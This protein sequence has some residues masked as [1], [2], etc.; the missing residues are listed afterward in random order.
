MN[1]RDSKPIRHHA[2]IDHVSTTDRN[3][4]NDFRADNEE[5]PITIRTATPAR[6]P[7]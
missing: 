1:D 6:H 2:S 5:Q 4:R 7:A 3:A